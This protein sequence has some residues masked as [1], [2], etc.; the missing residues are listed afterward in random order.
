MSKLSDLRSKG[1]EVTLSNNII[2][3]LKPM[4]LDEEARLAEFQQDNKPFDAMCMLVKNALKR[5]IPD[6]T[7][8]E[9]NDLN[10]DDLKIVSEEV[11]KLNGLGGS[12]I[13]KD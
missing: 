9:I 4:T 7:D 8:D 1:V 3:M 11:L 6:A 5:A 13:K 2:I 10:K 12:S